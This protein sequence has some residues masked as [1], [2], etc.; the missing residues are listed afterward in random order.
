MDKKKKK[1]K[2]YL[3]S[4][5]K[6]KDYIDYETSNIYKHVLISGHSVNPKEIKARFDKKVEE[7]KNNEISEKD[8]A[9]IKKN[10]YG[11]FVSE[12]NSVSDIARNVLTNWMKNVKNVYKYIEIF[13]EI[14]ISYIMKVLNEVFEEKKE[15]ISIIDKNDK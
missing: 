1:K 3:N 15:I 13:D 10:L 8:F 5:T 4:H 11:S 7:F 12:F 14:N 6:I 2:W 9:R